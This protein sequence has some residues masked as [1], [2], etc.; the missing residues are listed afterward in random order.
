MLL[1]QVESVL[2]IRL[3]LLR[4]LEVMALQEDVHERLSRATV[5]EHYKL[6]VDMLPEESLQ[7]LISQLVTKGDLL[8][9]LRE[10][11]EFSEYLA[12]LYVQAFEASK[13]QEDRQ[14][15]IEFLVEGLREVSKGTWLEQLSHEGSLADLVMALAKEDISPKLGQNFHDALLN[16]VKQQL[17]DNQALPSVPKEE[18]SKLLNAMDESEKGA[19]PNY[20]LNDLIKHSE[21]TIQPV[22][23]LYGDMLPQTDNIMRK[24]DDVVG[25]LFK[26][27][28]EKSFLKSCAG[29]LKLFKNARRSCKAMAKLIKNLFRNE[30]TV[31]GRK[32]K[33]NR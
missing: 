33:T 31:H 2:E 18:W 27:V 17:F 8:H 3:L 16:H 20:L 9:E 19:F 24:A 15:F 7:H 25:Q 6:L 29:S 22:L 28:L 1:K 26:G 5:L 23:E 10:E 30:S 32:R 12:D 11:R 4:I 21:A 13:G 14:T